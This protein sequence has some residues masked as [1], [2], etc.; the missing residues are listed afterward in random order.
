MNQ[1]KLDIMSDLNGLI[2]EYNENKTLIEAA[3][4]EPIYIEACKDVEKM[5]DIIASETEGLRKDMDHM[6]AA[7]KLLTLQL[8]ET[9]DTMTME[10]KYRKG[11]DRTTWDSKALAVHA[12]FN[13]SINQYRKTTPV[14]PTV[15]ITT[16]TI[17][18]V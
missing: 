6:I 18:E 5:S 11:Y 12:E 10:I 8:G 7:I 3:Y 1:N 9:Y 13:P 14:L 16:R 4:N 2:S 15:S 17:G